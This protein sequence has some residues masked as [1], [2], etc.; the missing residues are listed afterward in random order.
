MSFNLIA[1]AQV[2]AEWQDLH[3]ELASARRLVELFPVPA[4]AGESDAIGISVPL[5]AASEDVWAELVVILGALTRRGMR[6]YDLQAGR[7]VLS[8]EELRR[9]L[10]G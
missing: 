1:E 4:E 3:S 7:E 8:F 9:G 6:I 5:R 2:Q 10:W